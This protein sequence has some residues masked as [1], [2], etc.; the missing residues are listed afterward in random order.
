MKTRSEKIRL[1]A[2]LIAVLICGVSVASCASGKS[3]GRV[4]HTIFAGTGTTVP[5]P[6]STPGVTVSPVTTAGSG[7]ESSVPVGS[8]TGSDTTISGE[9]STSVPETSSASPD[10]TYDCEIVT[11]TEELGSAGG[12]KSVRTLK[13]PKIG[14]LSDGAIQDKVNTLIA[15]IADAKFGVYVTNVAELL[16][17]G[18]GVD[19]KVTETAVTYLG[20]NILSLRSAG[21]VQYS[22]KSQEKENFIYCNFINLSTGKELKSKTVYSDFGAVLDMLGSGVFTRISGS[23]DDGLADFIKLCK[24]NIA[25]GVYPETYFT[26]D[27]LVIVIDE[28]LSEY[29]VPLDKVNA[30]L[31][32]SPTKN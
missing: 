16:K 27:S 6:E 1:I 19:Y 26:A 28:T 15:N 8:D 25:Y 2:V 11:V 17:D 3:G 10:M 31:T 30:Y 32:V 21:T 14:G 7:D 23:G 29:S 22:G 18:T 20:N 9:T 5:A 12:L 24:A 4:I 13:Y